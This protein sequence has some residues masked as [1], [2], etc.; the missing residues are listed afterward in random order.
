MISEKFITEMVDNITKKELA[1]YKFFTDYNNKSVDNVKLSNGTVVKKADTNL[2]K[3]SI[4]K[5]PYKQIRSEELEHKIATPKFVKD[6]RL[7]Y[8]TYVSPILKAADEELN[9]GR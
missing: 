5:D 9:V 4:F 3:I 2:D 6:G 1:K 7:G 8:T